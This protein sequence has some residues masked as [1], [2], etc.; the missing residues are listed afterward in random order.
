V[1]P[2]HRPGREG[3]ATDFAIT[4]Q[5]NLVRSAAGVWSLAET[6]GFTGDVI[7]R[8]EVETDVIFEDGFEAGA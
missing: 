3:F 5:R 6:A 1:Q 8:L 7:L 2:G 4:P